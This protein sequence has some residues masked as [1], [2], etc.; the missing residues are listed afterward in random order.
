MTASDEAFVERVQAIYTHCMT[1]EMSKGTS[2]S[3]K[4][5][6]MDPSSLLVDG[7]EE[8]TLRVLLMLQ[9]HVCSRLY[10]ITV[11][12]WALTAEAVKAE[13]QGGGGQ[14]GRLVRSVRKRVGLVV[15]I[16]ATTFIGFVIVSIRL[17]FG[18]A[19]AASTLGRTVSSPSEMSAAMRKIRSAAGRIDAPAGGDGGE[20]GGRAATD[21]K[22]KGKLEERIIEQIQ[23]KWQ[24]IFGEPINLDEMDEDEEEEPQ[25]QTGGRTEKLDTAYI[26]DEEDMGGAPVGGGGG[27]AGDDEGGSRLPKIRDNLMTSLPIDDYMMYRG[28]PIC[29]YMERT[30]PW[31][32]FELQ[33]LEIITFVFNSSGAVLVGLGHE[34][35][36]YVALTVAIAGVCK[37]F[38]EF[39]RLS[40][41]VEAYNAA[42][43]EIH[44]MINQWDGMTRTQRRTRTTITNVVTTVETAFLGVCAALTDA[45]PGQAFGMGGGEDEGSDDG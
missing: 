45:V 16:V 42:Q 36:P 6:G 24:R 28:R 34:Y 20:D 12:E 27:G 21:G 37:S 19:R 1:S 29:T 10:F 31:R 39:S 23:A 13:Q 32:A 41:Q 2:A 11:K 26:E 9:E 25:E 38:I 4:T 8:G 18:A 30:A 35:V 43:R 22:G 5:G 14:L 44:N 15:S 3:H 33:C 7:D 17:S 40:Q